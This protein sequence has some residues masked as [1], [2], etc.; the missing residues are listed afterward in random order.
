MAS[1]KT[2]RIINPMLTVAGLL[3]MISGILMLFHFESHLVVVLHELMGLGLVVL[4]LVH[5]A[6]NWRPLLI[7]LGERRGRLITALV[8]AGVAAVMIVNG[9]TD[10]RGHARHKALEDGDRAAPDTGRL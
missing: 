2:R 10:P 3:T 4:A 8:I 6:L 7:S 5:L 9:V 1:P